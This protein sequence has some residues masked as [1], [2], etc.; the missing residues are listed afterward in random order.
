MEA[1]LYADAILDR[2]ESIT[3]I[4]KEE[5][6]SMNRVPN[7]NNVRISTYFILKKLGFSLN[8]IARAMNRVNHTTIIHGIQS[9]EDL[10]EAN[11]KDLIN[12]VI[13]Y[14][15]SSEGVEL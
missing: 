15:D 11:D 9:F 5:V 12:I 2:F 14:A 4:K 6:L 1:K 3:N 7:V 10:L 8:K 13:K